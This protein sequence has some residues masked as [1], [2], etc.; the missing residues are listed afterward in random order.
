MPYLCQKKDVS[1]LKGVVTEKAAFMEKVSAGHGCLALAQ[2]APG[3]AATE[4]P[5]PVWMG[6]PR[7]PHPPAVSAVQPGPGQAS[8]ESKP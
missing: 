6:A 2:S 4:G 1:S 5:N 7:R 8:R 3:L